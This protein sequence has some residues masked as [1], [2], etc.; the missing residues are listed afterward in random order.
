[1]T[2]HV[3]IGGR[4]AQ[5]RKAAGL[6]QE[7][8][9]GR[10]G[11]HQSRV[12][13]MESGD[14]EPTNE[15]YT[16]Y[17]KAVGTAEASKLDAAINT[18][19]RFLPQP[20]LRHPDLVPLMEAETA[21]ARL[22]AFK[23]GPSIPQVLAGQAD[24]LFRRLFEFGEFLLNLDHRIV[25]VGEIGVGKTTAAC[26]Q[27]G[28]V[29]NPF[30]PGDLKGM[31]LDTGGGRTTLCDVH[32]QFGERFAI[33]VDPVP[34]EEIYRLVEE[35]CRSIVTKAD[36]SQAMSSTAD[37]KLP[38]EVERALRVM[39]KLPRPV[40]RKGSQQEPD[41]ATG[42]ADGRE[43]AD[44]KAEVAARLT[45]WRRTRRFIDF[46]GSDQLAG[47]TWLRETFT[48][49]NNGRHDDFS[50]PEKIIV[51]VPFDPVPGSHYK[52]SVLDTRGVDGSAIRP[53]ILAQLKDKRTLTVLCAK[54]GSAPDPSI[55]EL[56]KHMSETDVDPTL[57]SRVAIL[58]VARAGDA[59][60]MRH[61]SGESALDTNE[62]YEIKRTQV[63]DA[64][65]RINMTGIAVEP[66]DA[67]SDPSTD[68]TNF[69][70]KKLGELRTAQRTNAQSTIMA[71]EQMLDNVKK[72]QALATLDQ[73]NDDLRIFAESHS[74]LKPSLRP[75][76][77]RLLNSVRNTHPRTV[78]ASTRRGGEFWNFDV[79]QHL[80][81]G[82]AAEAKKRSSP[83]IDGLRELIKNRLSNKKF[84]T[85]HAFLGQ[86]LDD[87]SG[88]EA[89]F[90]NAARHHAV[91]VFKPHLS[92][93]QR[94]WLNTEGKYGQGLNY[95]EEVASALEAWFDEREGL[96]DAF[97]QQMRRAWRA[98]VLQRLRDASGNAG[99]AEE[100]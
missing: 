28:L 20:P 45:L 14:G 42:L 7:E 72:A 2:L 90:V 6:T 62:G 48:K 22:D 70:V 65:H 83:P 68:I 51:T 61:D 17:L 75:I 34:D 29:I 97:E 44:F 33:E 84:E 94:L 38:E 12:S 31:M 66:F 95:R 58:V 40:R 60:S 64:L 93:A 27:A 85:A 76:Q 87:V 73:I 79:F 39:A 37:F 99:A 13:R 91:A 1:M 5:T 46:E 52:V 23:S 63:E 82:A 54:W 8:L 41:P 81:D 53:D 86:I 25:Y 49:I 57:F 59:L 15:D 4:L 26:K 96:Q 35:F 9:A 16:A 24:L 50:L 78:W 89:D 74:R 80:G 71:I 36:P 19:W 18:K 56:L 100:S 3:E 67:A 55:Q 11:L 43:F 88:W 77:T 10:L 47:R 92:K 98:S 69:L 21:L 30:A 32:V